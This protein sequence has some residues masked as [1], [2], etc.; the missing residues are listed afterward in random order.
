MNTKS[1]SFRL[2]AG[3]V[4]LFLAST[5]LSFG[6]FYLVTKRLLFSHTDAS[7][8]AHGSKV[9]QVV[10][11]QEVGM[12]DALAKEAF[13]REFS[14]IPGMLVVIMDSGGM[15]VSS[16]LADRS[17]PAF[18]ELF[19]Q[20]KRQGQQFFADRVIGEVTMRWLALPITK[21]GV[22]VGSVL[23]AHPVD[24]IAKSLRSLV[25]TEAGVFLA[26][27]VPVIGLGSWLV[28]QGLNPVS[29]M[30]S[31]MTQIESS[32]LTARMTNPK[33]ADA[34]EDLAEAFNGLLDRLKASFERE[35][36][37][38]GDVAHEIK[39][40]LST[41]SGTAEVALSRLRTKEDYKRVLNEILTDATKMSTTL[42]NV[43][44]L[45]WS[46]SGGSALASENFS[47]S[48]MAGELEEV[49][50]KLAQA[51]HI[52][53]KSKIEKQITFTGR[54][55][56]L[57]RAVLNLIDNAIKFTPSG[58][59]LSLSL[60]S[61]NDV[62]RI[63]VADTGAG[64]AAADLP[65]IFERFYRGSRTGKTLGSGLGL[66]IAASIVAA[67]RGKIEV[68]SAVGKGSKFAVFLTKS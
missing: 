22:F 34:V 41:I 48:E 67:H 14:E 28:R 5:L 20:V 45:A 62:V 68:E 58:G 7:L 19:D 49:A 1:L 30:A 17:N 53:V 18:T 37:F 32:D 36:Q 31:K 10:A 51:K 39:T 54:R 63:E 29:N 43:M 44:D 35:R 6:G 52:V 59:E 2:T 50:S 42:R 38:I 13:I 15:V 3:M 33:T 55:E 23:V 46:Q 8:V 16:S 21:N 40:P 61:H 57:Y 27:V 4:A 26:L 12:H 11:A 64:I 56:K 24:V 9:V 65:H 60:S 25:M 47:L 66:A